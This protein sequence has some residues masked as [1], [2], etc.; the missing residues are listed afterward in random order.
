M[1]SR[2]MHYCI[3]HLIAEKLDLKGDNNFLLGSV[4]P[5]VHPYMGGVKPKDITHFKER[6]AAGNGHINYAR[7]YEKYKGRADGTFYLGYACHLIADQLWTTDMYTL[8]VQFMSEEQKKELMKATYRDFWRL[9]GRLLKM[10]SPALVVPE[11]P[12]GVGFEEFDLKAYLPTLLDWL[13]K[14]F[15]YKEDTA[16][17]QLEL[18]DNDNSQII[19]Y[20]EQSV[21]RCLSWIG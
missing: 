11:F 1:G 20:I 2:I 21:D 12:E 10:Y 15:D 16:N 7:F 18:F 8:I 6:D 4:A 3:G 9:N 19:Y 17:E 13:G 5:D 14:D